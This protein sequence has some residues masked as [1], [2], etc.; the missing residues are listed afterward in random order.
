MNRK[1]LI[2]TYTVIEIQTMLKLTKSNSKQNKLKT[3]V[4]S[5]ETLF[6][7]IKEFNLKIMP[8]MYGISRHRCR[9][10]LVGT[11]KVLLLLLA[12]LTA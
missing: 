3:S 9:N 2:Q 7:H 1:Q 6:T 10:K 5:R 4:S 11:R 8:D 12:P